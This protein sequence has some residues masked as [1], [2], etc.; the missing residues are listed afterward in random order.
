MCRHAIWALER[1]HAAAGAWP[2]EVK[3]IPIAPKT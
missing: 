3:A 2:A 1:Q